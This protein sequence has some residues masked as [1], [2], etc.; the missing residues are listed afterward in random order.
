MDKSIAGFSREL[1]LKGFVNIKITGSKKGNVI[2]IMYPESC[3]KDKNLKEAL[4]KIMNALSISFKV[5]VT[6]PFLLEKKINDKHEVSNRMRGLI[7]IIQEPTNDELEQLD[8]EL[9]LELDEGKLQYYNMFRNAINQDDIII[10]HLLLYHILMIIYDDKQKNID[11]FILEYYDI[12]TTEEKH[13]GN[14]DLNNKE[15]IRML[16]EN[17]VQ[18]LETR[19]FNNGKKGYETVFT[20]LRNQI[21]HKRRD[22]QGN[23]ITSENTKKEIKEIIDEF[24]EIVVYSIK[25]V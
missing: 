18:Y 17:K 25:S 22:I 10:Q 12:K 8:E 19:E 4:E 7:N 14:I 9:R 20:R 13:G 23:I 21:A 11:E 16:S 1:Q 6:N 24:K 3:C 15:S 2:L 5:K